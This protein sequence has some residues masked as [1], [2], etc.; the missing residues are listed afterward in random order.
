MTASFWSQMS[1]LLVTFHNQLS[2]NLLIDSPFGGFYKTL[3]FPSNKS[4]FGNWTVLQENIFIIQNTLRRQEHSMATCR[5]ESV[6]HMSFGESRMKEA[7]D[8]C[9]E[10]SKAL[11]SIRTLKDLSMASQYRVLWVECNCPHCSW[12]EVQFSSVQLSHVWLW[13]HGLQHTRLSCPSPTPRACSNSCPS[14]W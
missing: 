13:P 3:P 10:E 11:P 7:S 5:W 9:M 8:P 1:H 6:L 4:S 2:L 12:M 14:S